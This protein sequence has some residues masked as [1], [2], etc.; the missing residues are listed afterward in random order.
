MLSIT[1]VGASR[2]GLRRCAAHGSEKRERKYVNV[3]LFSF[4]GKMQKSDKQCKMI[5][6]RSEAL[7]QALKDNPT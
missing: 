4:T 3:I 1:A 6:E 5:A 7:L 2:Q